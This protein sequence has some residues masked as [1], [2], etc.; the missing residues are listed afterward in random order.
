MKT[1]RQI[2]TF[3]AVLFTANLYANV[4]EGSGTRVGDT[5]ANFSITRI[6]GSTFRL[7]DYKGKK[8]V[9]L[10]FWATWCANCKAEVPVL[11]TLYKTYGEEIE[12]LAI[13]VAV[14]DSLRRVNHYQK[15]YKLAYPLAFDES[16]EISKAYGI[17]G[18]P[19]QLIIDIN[20][21]IRY[22]AAETPEDIG[23]HIDALMGR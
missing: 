11:N 19:T 3:I 16:R 8:A 22:R 6:D 21:V 18:T 14:N 2:V 15:K 5:A 20:G 1:I 13:N 4:E 10:I 12:V 9:N 7:S 17:V 23:E